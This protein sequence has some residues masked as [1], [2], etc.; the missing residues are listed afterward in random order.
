MVQLGLGVDPLAKRRC[1]QYPG[2]RQLSERS[3]SS[4]DLQNLDTL[5]HRSQTRQFAIQFLRELSGD[6]SPDLVL[7]RVLFCR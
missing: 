5:C 6:I 1:Y 2:T 4:I 3:V 7:P